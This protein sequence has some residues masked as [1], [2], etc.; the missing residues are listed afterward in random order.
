MKLSPQAA[1]KKHCRACYGDQD[2]WRGCDN[3]ECA[4]HL[5]Y[6]DRPSSNVKRIRLFCRQ[7]VETEPMIRE[8]DGETTNMGDCPL[9]PFRMAKNPNRR[10][11]GFGKTVSHERPEQF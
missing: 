5:R 6:P 3:N 10:G 7:C 1:I 2:A 4:L 9:H 8:C 11:I